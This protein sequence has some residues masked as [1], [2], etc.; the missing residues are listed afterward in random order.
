MGY[1]TSVFLVVFKK[2][3]PF[4]VLRLKV[5]QQG[6]MKVQG[7][8]KIEIQQLDQEGNQDPCCWF[9]GLTS[10]LRSYEKYGLIWNVTRHSDK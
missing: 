8:T 4:C 9:D 6:F 2:A 10:P 3:L 1:R 7:V 5:Q